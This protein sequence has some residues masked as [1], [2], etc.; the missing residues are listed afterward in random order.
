MLRDRLKV[1]E[2]KTSLSKKCFSCQ[3]FDHFV[4]E[5]PLLHYAPSRQ[6]AL[7]DW[8]FLQNQNRKIFE[9]NIKAKKIKTLFNLKVIHEAYKVLRRNNPYLFKI[10]GK[11]N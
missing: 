6:I 4:L 11:K 2:D 8:K 5:C 7:D 9:R 10:N 1:Y 3:S